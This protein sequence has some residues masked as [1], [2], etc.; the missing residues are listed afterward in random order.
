MFRPR[1]SLKPPDDL[2]GKQLRFRIRWKANVKVDGRFHDLEIEDTS[3][4]ESKFEVP[5]PDEVKRFKLQLPFLE[6]GS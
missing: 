3:L 4:E 5:T 2:L 6:S 1:S